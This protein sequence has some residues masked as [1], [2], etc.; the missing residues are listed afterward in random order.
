VQ[1]AKDGDEV[2]GHL[3]ARLHYAA[4]DGAQRFYAR[5]GFAV[6]SVI[7]DLDDLRSGEPR[8]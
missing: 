2:V 7:L 3:V 1:L 6:K 8:A 5:H 4:N